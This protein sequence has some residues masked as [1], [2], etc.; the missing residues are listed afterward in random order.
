MLPGE[1][2]SKAKKNKKKTNKKNKKNSTKEHEVDND[3]ENMDTMQGNYLL[4]YYLYT[5]HAMLCSNYILYLL[6]NLIVLKKLFI[7]LYLIIKHDF[8]S[9]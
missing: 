8:S 3:L 7:S 5:E 9:M 4:I 1:K 2:K 6:T